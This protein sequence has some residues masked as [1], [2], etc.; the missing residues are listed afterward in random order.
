MSNNQNI[1]TDT[2]HN[3]Y[4]GGDASMGRIPGSEQ[5][6][7]GHHFVSV[8]PKE[9]QQKRHADG[10]N[11]PDE[12]LPP[13]T[14]RNVPPS[15]V[16]QRFVPADQGSITERLTMVQHHEPAPGP[17]FQ[18]TAQQPLSPAP[19]SRTVID[20][21]PWATPTTAADTLT[22]A[23]SKDVHGGIGKP[24]SGM[25]SAEMHHDGQHRRKRQGLGKDQYGNADE[26]WAQDSIDRKLVGTLAHARTLRNSLVCINQLPPEVLATIFAAI[27]EHPS[28]FV[29]AS[30][31]VAVPAD[32]PAILGVCRYWRTLALS[33]PRLWT[34]IVITSVLD[35]DPSSLP[36]RA[37]MLSRAA[38]LSVYI[39]SPRILRD[40]AVYGEI[41]KQMHRMQ[42]L[43]ISDVQSPEDIGDFAAQS[44]PMLNTFVV[45]SSSSKER[46][47]EHPL[48]QVPGTWPAG[49]S[50][51]VHHR[52]ELPALFT[53]E[54]PRLVHL[55]LE[56][57]KIALHD[58]GAFSHL[59][60]LCLRPHAYTLPRDLTL[61]LNLLDVNAE[62][63]EDLAIADVTLTT[64]PP[65]NPHHTPAMTDSP[66]TAQAQ[67]LRRVSLPRLRR[68]VFSKNDASFVSLVLAHVALPAHTSM[69]I[70]KCRASG[71]LGARKHALLPQDISHLENVAGVRVLG[72]Q[73]IGATER[74]ICAVTP[75]PRSDA[76][77]FSIDSHIS[78]T[79]E[80]GGSA[81]WINESIYGDEW[82]VDHLCPSLP[83][84]EIQELWLTGFDNRPLQEWQATFGAMR[85]LEKLV[86]TD[87][88]WSLED[89]LSA[90]DSLTDNE[91]GHDATFICP[92]LRELHVRGP[93]ARS[94]GNLS[95]FVRTRAMYGI[96]L[97]RVH[98]MVAAD[99]TKKVVDV[100]TARADELRAHVKEVVVE[101]VETFPKMRLPA[102][103]TEKIHQRAYW[104]NW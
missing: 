29:Q 2:R 65:P 82:L 41:V 42:E 53:S 11:R 63:L 1:V 70:A 39:H 83:L 3:D 33:T 62:T 51:H 99:E 21:D 55:G 15:G 85:A 32:W 74:Y 46:H 79:S 102:V 45:H 89:W 66:N 13:P 64:L 35:D 47:F 9:G 101:V 37:L 58:L 7:T 73:L 104:P 72:L 75:P 92:A 34:R 43:H 56:K 67:P 25:S 4:V 98:V 77:S 97:Q 96:P 22:G 87:C 31:P 91:S 48:A 81:L 84:A 6:T 69:R 60:S 100:Y 90:L 94:V 19:D 23:T 80:N 78:D 44:A 14:G 52:D 86:F 95:S 10:V 5:A 27:T 76:S 36:R 28:P 50:N 61:L 8:F 17:Q 68:L 59:R 57:F 49:T 38:P 40:T 24:A 18:Q 16:D 20:K 103:C 30:G 54:T 88:S 93:L 12:H 26:M 71:P